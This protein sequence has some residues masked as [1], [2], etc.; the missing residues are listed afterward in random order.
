[1]TGSN[2]TS[3]KELIDDATNSAA[4]PVRETILD[5]LQKLS[6]NG[7]VLEMRKQLKDAT[8]IA[9]SMALAGQITVFYAG[10]N[11]GKTLL[12][13]KL[14]AEAAANGTVGQH[15]YHINLDD[16]YRGLIE[17]GE[18]GERHGFQV[19]PPSNFPRPNENFAELVD[20]LIAESL[21][22][23]TVFI[24]DTTKKF[25]DVMDKKASSQ[26]MHT[27]RRLT[28]TGGTIIALSHLNKHR[29]GDGI[30]IP[31]G[32]SDVLDDCDCAYV[33]DI[34]HEEQLTGAVKRSV[35]FVQKKNRGPST[36]QSTYSYI[37]YEDGDYFKMFNSVQ[38]IDGN[39]ADQLRA[40]KAIEVEKSQDA[41]A[42]SAISKLLH[43]TPGLS[44][45]AI[46]EA[47][48]DN[49]IS[50]RRKLVDCLK[51]WDC[52]KEGGGLWSTKK[53]PNNSSTY[54]LTLEP[55]TL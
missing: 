12:T 47:V 7:K 39:A 34:V 35:E 44:Q 45:T 49:G 16:T 24:L 8:F 22:A 54:W 20:C 29:D 25:V 42:I 23:E 46:V 27:C 13:L 33:M 3:C 40:Q 53:G 37:K 1:M 14:I 11:T 55:P 50:S 5:L 31:G 9:G 4:Q 30:G 38:V 6:I 18:L 51:R 43:E 15:V 36:T 2:P 52:P 10:P 21:G 26:F 19:I 48:H 41:L 28:E 17:K 32:T